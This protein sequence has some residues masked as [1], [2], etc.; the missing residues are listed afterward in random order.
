MASRLTLGLMASSA[1][2]LQF[3]GCQSTTH[4]PTGGMVTEQP[5][6][7]QLG[8][9]MAPDAK[10]VDFT[11]SER[12]LSSVFGDVTIIAFTDTESGESSELAAAGRA[13]QELGSVVEV[14]SDPDAWAP[15][16]AGN[17]PG[18]P[19]KRSL[20]TLRDPDGILRGR[21]GGASAKAIFLINGNGAIVA[22][23]TLVDISQF[24]RD[25]KGL[26]YRAEQER[27]AL[28]GG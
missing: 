3:L 9:V 16:V 5:I 22:Q 7:E 23:G 6:Q 28:Y 18:R 11:G 17:G 25:A 27:E 1:F 4:P 19:E 26:A 20:V 10:F 24:V 8:G 2:A 21:Y 15:T 14:T 12:K 13:L